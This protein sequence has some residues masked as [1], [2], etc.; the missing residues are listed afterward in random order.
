MNE[1]AE[2]VMDMPVLREDCEAVY[3]SKLTKLAQDVK[4]GGIQMTGSGTV[5][6]SD[7]IS[8]YLFLMDLRYCAS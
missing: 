8:R 5:C 1:H 2:E 7:C 6:C 3:V 4:E